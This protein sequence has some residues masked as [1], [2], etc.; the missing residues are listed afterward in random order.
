MHHLVPYLLFLRLYIKF[1]SIVECPLNS[2]ITSSLIFC[3]SACISN[4]PLHRSF[5]EH[6][7][8]R[9][10]SSFSVLNNTSLFSSRERQNSMEN[11]VASKSCNIL[12][13]MVDFVLSNKS[14]VVSSGDGD[15]V[16]SLFM[17]AA[18]NPLLSPSLVKLSAP[19]PPSS[20]PPPPPPS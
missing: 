2:C 9:S 18:V 4:S 6:T 12:P 13:A 1:A 11:R 3:F 19:P 16:K 10:L 17:P 20:G 8:A 14:M 5:K 15:P 7:R